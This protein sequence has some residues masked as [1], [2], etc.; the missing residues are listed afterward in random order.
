MNLETEAYEGELAMLRKHYKLVKH[1]EKLRRLR[2]LVDAKVM[3]AFFR[4]AMAEAAATAR[5]LA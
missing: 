2:K 1:I 5:Y 3:A 4:K